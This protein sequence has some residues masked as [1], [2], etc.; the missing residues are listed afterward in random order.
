MRRLRRREKE[1]KSERVSELQAALGVCES[2]SVCVC[3]VWFYI[4]EHRRWLSWK[5]SKWAISLCCC[6]CIFGWAEQRIK[7]EKRSEWMSE[8]VSAALDMKWALNV[9]CSAVLA[10]I[11]SV[12]KTHSHTQPDTHAHRQPVLTTNTTIHRNSWMNVCVADVMCS[13]ISLGVVSNL[14]YKTQIRQG[15]ARTTLWLGLVKTELLLEILSFSLFLS[16]K[17]IALPYTASR[18]VESQGQ[19]GHIF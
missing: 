11:S 4:I 5:Q 6:C 14:H 15:K 16:L 9:L 8:W 17:S 2:L 18:T 1:G 19:H 12:A 10:L 13:V 3:S 7:A